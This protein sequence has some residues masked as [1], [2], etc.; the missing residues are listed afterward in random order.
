MAQELEKD[1][2][3]EMDNETTK[4]KQGSGRGFAGMSEDKRR[5]IASKGGKAQ[6]KGNN[7]GNFANNREKAVTAGRLGGQNSRGAGQAGSNDTNDS[8]LE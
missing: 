4:I 8:D 6:G 7:P 5:Q 3:S 2:Q 1:E